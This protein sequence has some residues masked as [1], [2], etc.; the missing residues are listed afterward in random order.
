VLVL[1]GDVPLLRPE[2]LR[3]LQAALGEGVATVLLT[4]RLDSPGAYGRVLRD[5]A[6][7]LTAVV[8]ARDASEGVLRVNE[9]NAGVYAL[10]PRPVLEALPEL[11]SDNRQGELYLTDLPPLLRRRGLGVHAVELDDPQEMTGVNSRADLAAVAAVL[12][13][14]TLERIMAAGV[15]V[16]DPGTTRVESAC[17]VEQDALLEP[18][19][20]L[21]GGCRVGRGARIGAHAVVDGVDIPPGEVVPPLSH[22][23]R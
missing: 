1:S 17:T 4:A 5:E 23:G 19:V 22:R 3:R 21:R 7:E 2:T 10:R 8:E 6:G 12:N 16:L 13:R 9:V 18:G 20:V 14:R 11:T 15:T